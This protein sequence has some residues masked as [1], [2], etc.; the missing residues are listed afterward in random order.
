[1]TNTGD[2]QEAADILAKA[3]T[4]IIDGEIDGKTFDLTESIAG[5]LLFAGAPDV[6]V[7]INS[8]GGVTSAGLD[9][10]DILDTYPGHKTAVVYSSALSCASIIL[11]A[12]DERLCARHAEIK[13]HD[14]A[15]EL[16]LTIARNEHKFA[17]WTKER[18]KT[19]AKIDRIFCERTGLPMKRIRA[20]S[21]KNK[22]LAPTEALRY[23]LIDRILTKADMAKHF[24]P[25]VLEKINKAQ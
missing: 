14:V 15:M 13:I 23:N 21:E 22:L 10:F 12:C 24:R 11:Q 9:I 6:V 1:M 17:M 8:R 5:R 16:S 2:R 3:K 4:F 19:Q 18:E 25:E 7:I 20:L